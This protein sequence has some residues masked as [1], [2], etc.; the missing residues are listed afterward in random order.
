MTARILILV[1]EFTIQ[2]VFLL[3]A[4]WI[5]IK[6]QKLNYNFLGLLGAAVL[7]SLLD[8]IPFVGHPLSVGALLLCIWKITQSEYVDVAF[9]VFVGYALMFGM[10][11]WLIG[12]LMGDLRPSARSAD[13]NDADTEL[14]AE[15]QPATNQSSPP[16]PAP[17]TNMT[18]GT[19][20]A[21]QNSGTNIASTNVAKPAPLTPAE[22]IVK[23]ITLK[24]LS[25]NSTNSSLVLNTGVKTYTLLLG[26]LR[27]VQ[28]RKGTVAVRFEDLGDDWVMLNIASE[29]VKLS[30]H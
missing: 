29:P 7:A 6:L 9:T 17:A 19:F 28:T 25:R 26:E 27:S 10:N 2:T 14:P 5:M 23:D 13:D 15:Y 1:I 11:L 8:M 30:L 3:S 21:G 16:M 20:A 24:G 12:A 4:L 22:A 18:A